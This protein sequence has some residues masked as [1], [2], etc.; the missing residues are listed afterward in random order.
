LASFKNVQQKIG[1]ND[2]GLFAVAY[3]I[4]LC[5]GNVPSLLLYDQISL[6]DHYI[7][8]IENN[9]IQPFFSKPKRRSARNVSKL[10]DLYLN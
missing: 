2:C 5:Y 7:K 10:I 3:A 6:S 1:G 4:S 8:C 9:K